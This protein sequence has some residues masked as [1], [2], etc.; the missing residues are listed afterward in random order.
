MDTYWQT[1]SGGI[2]ICTLPGVGYMIPGSTGLP[3]FGIKPKVH[4]QTLSED[5]TS[6][7]LIEMPWPGIAR[8]VLNAHSKYLA[9]YFEQ[10]PGFENI[11][12]PSLIFLYRIIFY[13]RWGINQ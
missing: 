9:C 7:L 1:E 11:I 12:H 3:F 10:Y 13:W 4:Q 6:A 5:S 2:L 8:T